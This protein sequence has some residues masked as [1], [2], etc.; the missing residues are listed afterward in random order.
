MITIPSKMQDT[1]YRLFISCA[2]VFVAVGGGVFYG[3]GPEVCVCETHPQD[4]AREHVSTV[5]PAPGQQLV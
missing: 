2:I 4:R 3:E 5:S 1:V